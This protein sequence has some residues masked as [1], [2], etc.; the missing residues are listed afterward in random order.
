MLYLDY[1]FTYYL[2]LFICFMFSFYFK[3]LLLTIISLEF[4]VI[5]LIFNMFYIFML[6][7]MNMYLII[8]FM[9]LTV[10]EGALSLSLIVLM[11][12]FYGND[13]I[14]SLMILKW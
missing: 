7:E 2:F 12:R 1:L 13:Y 11:V 9:T 4:M 6:V 5:L 8:L 3:H 14:N 10:C